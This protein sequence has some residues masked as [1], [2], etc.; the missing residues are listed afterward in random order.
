MH[1][2]IVVVNM[3]EKF[4][5]EGHHPKWL[6]FCGFEFQTA[7]CRKHGTAISPHI[8]ARFCS[9]VLP[10]DIRGRRECRAPDAPAASCVNRKHTS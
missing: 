3:P 8:C 4:E 1:S 7:A 10:P 2:A 9:I 5:A 6:A